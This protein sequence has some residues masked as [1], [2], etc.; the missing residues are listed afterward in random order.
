M[1]YITRKNLTDLRRPDQLVIMDDPAFNVDM[2][3]PALD[4]EFD[5]L[6]VIGDAQRSSQSMLSIQGGR[7]GSVS[8][9]RGSEFGIN[10]PSS[11]THTGGY[12]LSMDDRFDGSGQKDYGGTGRDIFDEQEMFEDDV[13]FEFDANGNMRDVDV[14]ERKARRAGSVHPLGP[15]ER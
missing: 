13:L 15:L 10:L 4:F 6:N 11:S 12:Q 7:S 5:N 1:F 2:A 3:L 9:H 14:N 8:S